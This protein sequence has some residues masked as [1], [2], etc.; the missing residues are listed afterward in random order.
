MFLILNISGQGI[1]PH[2]IMQIPN[3]F[4]SDLLHSR[5]ADKP[6]TIPL[7]AADIRISILVDEFTAVLL[8]VSIPRIDIETVAVNY[9]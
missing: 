6:K 7:K 3:T 4:K 9:F 8:R 1:S 5:Y 2:I